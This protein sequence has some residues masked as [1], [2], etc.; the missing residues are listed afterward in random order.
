MEEDADDDKRKNTLGT[1]P[2]KA[3]EYSVSTAIFC[4]VKH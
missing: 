4:S 2:R 3:C 1:Q